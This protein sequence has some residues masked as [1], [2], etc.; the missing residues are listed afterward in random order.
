MRNALKGSG[1]YKKMNDGYLRERSEKVK[2][3]LRKREREGFKRKK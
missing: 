1:R 2:H 3:C